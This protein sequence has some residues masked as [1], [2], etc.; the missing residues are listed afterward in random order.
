MDITSGISSFVFIIMPLYFTHMPHHIRLRLYVLSVN[1]SIYHIVEHNNMNKCKHGCQLLDGVGIIMVCN[2]FLLPQHNIYLMLFDI[3]TVALHSV[4]K[5]WFND[6]C[7]KKMIYLAV[8]IKMSYVCPISAIP[9]LCGFCGY[10][11]SVHNN[12]WNHYNRTIWH[13]GN[14]LFIGISSNCMHAIECA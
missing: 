12:S 10:L 8:F 4:L 5:V 6:E 3:C 13:I 11:H 9:F 14:A 7:I 1:S 2:T